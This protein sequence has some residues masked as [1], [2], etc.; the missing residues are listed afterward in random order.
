MNKL[1]QQEQKTYRII[2][3]VKRSPVRLTTPAIIM[4]ILAIV[5]GGRG[6]CFVQ[7]DKTEQKMNKSQPRSEIVSSA[8][9]QKIASPKQ[10]PMAMDTPVNRNQTKNMQPTYLDSN[11]AILLSIKSRVIGDLKQSIQRSGTELPENA[12]MAAKVNAW[13]QKKKK[14]LQDLFIKSIEDYAVQTHFDMDVATYLLVVESFQKMDEKRIAEEYTVRI[15]PFKDNRF[16]A[17]FWEDGL[18]VNSEAHALQW[19]NQLAMRFPDDKG[20]VNQVKERYAAI[21]KSIEAG[22]TERYTKIMALLYT[23][24]KDGSIIFHDPGQP[25]IDFINR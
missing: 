14:Q 16:A 6:Y 9:K 12:V 15:Q 11:D 21:R 25:M 1:K 2:T 23:K 7:P 4:A 20:I 22:K 5:F 19:A 8:K 18:A 3:T 17:E 13:P 10:T 24:E